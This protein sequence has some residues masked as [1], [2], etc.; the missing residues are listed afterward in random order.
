VSDYRRR[1]RDCFG[2]LE[3]IR[4]APPGRAVDA[5]I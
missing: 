5:G 3:R 2:V 4:T 1:I